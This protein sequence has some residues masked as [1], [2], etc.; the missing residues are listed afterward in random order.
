MS[1]DA[2]R[3]IWLDDGP[4]PEGTREITDCTV[5]FTLTALPLA[6]R[7]AV[8]RAMVE[9]ANKIL[10]ASNIYPC[11]QLQHVV[12]G[13]HVNLPRHVRGDVLPS[14]NTA[15]SRATAD[16]DDASIMDAV[17]SVA[18]Q[19]EAIGVRLVDVSAPITLYVDQAV[20][21]EDGHGTQASPFKT[22]A[23]ARQHARSMNRSPIIRDLGG[24]VLY[25]SE[26]TARTTPRPPPSP[27]PSRPRIVPEIRFH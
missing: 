2:A 16:E 12:E 15:V 18:H 3:G 1:D 26:L 22:I 13:L 27:P 21:R 7:A 24:R 8:V 23:R 14:V 10:H 4:L 5:T 9:A 6:S 17:N 20:G 11:P 19:L 25:S